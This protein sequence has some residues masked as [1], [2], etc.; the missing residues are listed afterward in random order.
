MLLM[1]KWEYYGYCSSTLADEEDDAATNKQL[2]DRVGGLTVTQLD[3]GRD[4]FSV[5]NEVFVPYVRRPSLGFL[6]G[7]RLALLDRFKT[8]AIT[9]ARRPMVN[10]NHFQ[11]I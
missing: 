9:K 6:S 5:F 8:C 7:F 1:M 2:L 10:R 11:I 3:L 4:E